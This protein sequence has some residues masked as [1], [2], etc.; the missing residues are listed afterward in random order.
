MLEKIGRAAQK[1]AASVPRRHFL[2]RLAHGAALVA[3]SL[4]GIL[5][6]AGPAGARGGGGE[7]CCITYNPYTN[8]YSCSKGQCRRGVRGTTVRCS[9]HPGLCPL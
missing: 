7:R 3:G 9:D 1:A 8:R 2:G 4:G 5:L 6:T